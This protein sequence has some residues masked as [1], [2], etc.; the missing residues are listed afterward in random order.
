MELRLY[1]LIML[2]PMIVTWLAG[3]RCRVSHRARPGYY[4]RSASPIWQMG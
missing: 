4:V 3:Q 1:K 2:P